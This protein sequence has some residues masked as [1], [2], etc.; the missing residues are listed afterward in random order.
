MYTSVPSKAMC[1][2]ECWKM[3]VVEELIGVRLAVRDRRDSSLVG[4][5]WME[6]SSSVNPVSWRDR[7]RG[8]VEQ[9]DVEAAVVVES[10]CCPRSVLA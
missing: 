8:Y 9:E 3:S 7:G 10:A 1:L 2:R 4:D 5:Q 6:C